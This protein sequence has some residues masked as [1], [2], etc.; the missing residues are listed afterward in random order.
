MYFLVCF[1]EEEG[2]RFLMLEDQ[3]GVQ[4]DHDPKGFDWRVVSSPSSGY[5]SGSDSLPESESRE[6]NMDS[7]HSY[8]KTCKGSVNPAVMEILPSNGHAND[9][10]G[11]AS[12]L[13]FHMDIPVSDF[14]GFIWPIQNNTFIEPIITTASENHGQFQNPA[15]DSY[16]P[17]TF[18]D[19]ELPEQPKEIRVCPS[20]TVG[21]TVANTSHNIQTQAAAS[22][23]QPS[24]QN[25][26]VPS[27]GSV[28][29]AKLLI[30]DSILVKERI[31]NQP[32]GSTSMRNSGGASSSS[33]LLPSLL[34]SNQRATDAYSTGC[35]ADQFQNT[36]SVPISMPASTVGLSQSGTSDPLLSMETTLPSQMIG[37]HNPT[38][39]RVNIT[40]S[41]VH[42]PEPISKKGSGDSI[43]SIDSDPFP[44]TG[45]AESMNLGSSE[46]LMNL[47]SSESLLKL[48][49]SDGLLKAGSG[50]SLNILSSDNSLGSLKNSSTGSSLP[51]DI[52]DIFMQFCEQ[53]PVTENSD[54]GGS[55]QVEQNAARSRPH[56][57]W[58]LSK[59]ETIDYTGMDPPVGLMDPVNYSD[60]GS[61]V[62]PHS[63]CTNT[64]VGKPTYNGGVD[65]M[66]SAHSPREHLTWSSGSSMNQ[67]SAAQASQQQQQ[68]QQGLVPPPLTMERRQGSKSNLSQFFLDDTNAPDSLIDSEAVKNSLREKQLADD[69]ISSL[70]TNSCPPRSEAGCEAAAPL[71][72]INRCVNGQV[73]PPQNSLA[74]TL[75]QAVAEQAVPRSTTYL[76]T[77]SPS[78]SL[79]SPS[80]IS[81]LSPLSQVPSCSE[82]G[83]P[84]TA[85]ATCHPTAAAAAAV[86]MAPGSLLKQMLL[87][88][89]PLDQRR[90]PEQVVA[91]RISQLKISER[92]EDRSSLLKK[93]LTGEVDYSQGHQ[94]HSPSSTTESSRGAHVQVGGAT[95]ST[96]SPDVEEVDY[97]SALSPNT[98]VSLQQPSLPA[99]TSQ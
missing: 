84:P 62:S 11:D 69:F 17:L 1:S 21:N 49:S 98:Q 10:P 13:P 43:M 41:S 58:Y 52:V 80:S 28:S 53:P 42:S 78:S 30:D 45:S 81:S 20:S 19:V 12:D 77:S 23:Q 57:E 9:R 83:P 29:L 66:S 90:Q 96:V 5:E 88:N 63:V 18:M 7:D 87:E 14:P 70:L 16:P 95:T 61:T 31:K 74:S 86:S 25:T 65:T 64:M 47:G 94:L 99:F 54:A 35:V 33:G 82:G 36:Q 22:M 75:L 85:A 8:V 40:V 32:G 3:D 48:L 39:S 76:Q 37:P 46:S 6:E 56:M 4:V 26:A 71:M 27:S 2:R 38:L 73:A 89:T 50:E 15:M 68:Q 92:K 24:L 91:E 60:L 59:G 72:G 67:Q 44:K 93:L 79:S 51:S 34:V 55:Q 97:F